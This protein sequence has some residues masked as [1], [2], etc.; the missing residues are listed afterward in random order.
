MSR[1]YFIAALALIVFGVSVRLL[2]HPDNFA[3]LTALAIFSGSLFPRRYAAFVPLV[4]AVLS[5]IFL[6]FYN[7]IPIVWGCYLVIALASNRWLKRPSLLQGFAFTIGSS[8][9]FFVVTNLAVW[10]FG[11]MYA[12]TFAGLSECFT[13]ALPFFRNSL[14]GDLVYTTSLFGLYAAAKAN[15]P[16]AS[17][18]AATNAR[19]K[20]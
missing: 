18:M 6:G 16:T 2:P 7:I 9:F 11:G 1:K 8:V 20:L 10:I 15:V 14:L 19:G 13:L 17:P 4:A 3:P 5:D 12:H